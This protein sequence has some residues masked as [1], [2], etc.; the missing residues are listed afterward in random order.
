MATSYRADSF[1]TD[2]VSEKSLLAKAKS[3]GPTQVNTPVI[4]EAGPDGQ[5]RLYKAR[6]EELE[7]KYKVLVAEKDYWMNNYEQVHAEAQKYLASLKDV[8]AQNEVLSRKVVD[9]EAVT[10]KIQQLIK[11]LK[12]PLDINE[13]RT[14]DG[15]L[16]AFFG[17][18]YTQIRTPQ[19]DADVLAD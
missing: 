6:Y 4:P 18:V 17:L 5:K 12:L 14:A 1:L 16:Q 9:T 10:K 8:R 15:A 2:Y 11:E 13:Y 7:A 3:K 19:E